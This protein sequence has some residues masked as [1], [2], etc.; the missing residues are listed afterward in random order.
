MALLTVHPSWLFVGG[1][2]LTEVGRKFQMA[3]VHFVQVIT[4]L[5]CGM[6]NE[7]VHT[8]AWELLH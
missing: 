5:E 1:L 7:C 4:E 8:S 6:W 2:K 3:V